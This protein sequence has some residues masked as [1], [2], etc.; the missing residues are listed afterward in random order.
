MNCRNFIFLIC[1]VQEVVVFLLQD[2]LEIFQINFIWIDI[3]PTLWIV[4]LN[5]V[6]FCHAVSH[7]L[8]Q[9]GFAPSFVRI[10]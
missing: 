2:N 7:S 1:F 6:Y 10:F 9:C 5:T 8:A 4:W 3:L